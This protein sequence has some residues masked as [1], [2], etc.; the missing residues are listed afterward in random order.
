MANPR[1]HARAGSTGDIVRR[2]DEYVY[3]KGYAG[4]M[5][6]AETDNMKKSEDIL[7]VHNF[8]DNVQ[9][10]SNAEEKPG[11]VYLIRKM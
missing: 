3:K 1:V 10:T 9:R 8:P 7:L 5:Y 4:T 11:Y 2:R 6:Y